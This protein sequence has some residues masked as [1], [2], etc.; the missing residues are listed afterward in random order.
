MYRAR[1][2]MGVALARKL[3]AQGGDVLTADVVVPVPDTSRPSAMQ[4][5]H[6]LGLP[7][8][9][10]RETDKSGCMF[11]GCVCGCG[12]GCVECE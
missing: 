7:F 8:R 6:E 5:A 12:C 3:R 4:L 11:C 2:A 1:L 9:E 10:V